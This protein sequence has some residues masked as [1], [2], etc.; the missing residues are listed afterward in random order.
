MATTQQ[1]HE[2]DVVQ[3]RRQIGSWP[4]GREGTVVAEKNG[5]KLIEIADEEGATLDFLSVAD[6]D[7]NVIWRPSSS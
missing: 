4:V 1:I 6:S 2:H 5:W 7:L 3:L